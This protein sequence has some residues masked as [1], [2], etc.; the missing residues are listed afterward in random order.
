MKE[1]DGASSYAGTKKNVC[2]RENDTN[3]DRMPRSSPAPRRVSKTKNENVL[4]HTPHVFSVKKTVD[5]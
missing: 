3:F 4:L 2:N 5:I 1:A